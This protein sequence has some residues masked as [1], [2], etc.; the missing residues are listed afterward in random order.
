MN[1]DYGWMKFYKAAVLETHSEVS[2]ERIEAAQ[3]AIRQRVMT[4]GHPANL[5]VQGLSF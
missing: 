4:V 3:K 5:D 2:P 1:V